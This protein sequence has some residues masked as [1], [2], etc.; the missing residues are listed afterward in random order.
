MAKTSKEKLFKLLSS[1]KSYTTRQLQSW[2]GVDRIA[3]RIHEMRQAGMMIQ[4]EIKTNSK[5]EKV[6]TYRFGKPT[7]SSLG[8]Q[9]AKKA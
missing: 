3:A 7:S 9:A 6:S 4:T 1:G 8:M 5:G 2:L